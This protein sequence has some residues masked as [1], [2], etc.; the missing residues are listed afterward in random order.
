MSLYGSI[1]EIQKNTEKLYLKLEQRFSGNSIIRE[2]W[3]KMAQ[4]LS[5]QIDSLH[6]LPKSFWIHLKN[7]QGKLLATIQA[8]V[9]PHTIDK[10][11]DLSL[12]ECIEN[13]IHSEEAIILK[14]Y[15]PLIRN[16]RK[17]WTGQELDFY[18]MVKAHIVRIKRVAQS[19]SGDPIVI[20]HAA[21]LFQTFEKE[22]QEPEVDIRQLL[23]PAR[24]A[25]PARKRTVA[26]SRKTAAGKKTVK[27][28]K[29]STASAKP[30]KKTAKPAPKSVK[31]AKK[32]AKTASESKSKTK[33]ATNKKSSTLI[34]RSKIR[35]SR[36][37]SLVEKT[38]PRRR[39][40]QR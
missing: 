38:G 21:T 32:T 39:R 33:K 36:T 10:T 40:A 35:R 16:L 27:A 34:N 37:K 17:N 26:K 14:I 3:S 1:K 15:V 25:R 18:I 23:K 6:E 22:I 4:D 5:Q 12:S 7:D 11:E 29:K 31:Q 2:L 8:E 20:Q 28:T 13:A 9:K 19:F 24:K 30:A